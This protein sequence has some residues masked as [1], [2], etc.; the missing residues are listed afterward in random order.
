MVSDHLATKPSSH[1]R[2]RHQEVGR[3][4]AQFFLKPFPRATK[5]IGDVCKQAMSI[6]AIH[7]A[8][9]NRKQFQCPNIL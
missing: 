7:I 9:D 1:Q 5:E 4:L 2:N 6:S 3:F 8:T